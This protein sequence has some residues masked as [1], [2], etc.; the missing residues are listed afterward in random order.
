MKYLTHKRILVRL[1]LLLFLFASVFLFPWWVTVILAFTL[2]FLY[3]APEVLV[4]GVL[5]DGFYPSPHHFLDIHFFFTIL[6]AGFL[7]FSVFAKRF[8]IMYDRRF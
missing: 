2:S 1:F 6:L 7:L 4:A 3:F 5:L 8:L